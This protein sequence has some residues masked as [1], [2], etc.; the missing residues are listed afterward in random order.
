MPLLDGRTNTIREQD[1]SVGEAF[2]LKL[3]HIVDEKVHVRSTGFYSLITQQPVRG[4]SRGGGQ[5]IGEMEIWALQSFGTTF[6]LQEI[7]TAKSDDLTGRRPTFLESLL[8]N[9]S[10]LVEI[11]DAF[12]ILSC[13]LQALC[14]DLSWFSEDF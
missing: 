1:V 3:I 5:R 13:E 7:I 9:R 6:T 4:R 14:F 2:F 10:L 11:P 12:R 8:D